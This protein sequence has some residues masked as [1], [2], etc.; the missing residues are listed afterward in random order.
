LLEVGPDGSCQDAPKAEFLRVD[1]VWKNKR[2]VEDEYLFEECIG[3]GSFGRV[4][5]ALHIHSGIHRAIKELPKMETLAEDFDWELRALIDLDHPHIVQ[6]IEH[7]EEV[8]KY[9]IVMELCTGPDLFTYIVEN[10]DAAD[11]NGP[12]FIPESRVSVILRQCLKAVLCCHAHGFIHRDLNAKNFMMTGSDQSVKLID[13][14]LATRFLPEEKYEEVVGTA[15]YMAPEMMLSGQWTTAVDIW[16]LGVVFFV[17]LTGMLLLPSDDTKK[18]KMISAPGFAQQ[19]LEKCKA[20][21]IRGLSDIARNLLQ[22]ML[23]FEPSA[24]I[25]APQALSH[26]FIHAHCDESLGKSLTFECDFD[27]EVVRKMRRFARAPRLMKV[28]LLVMAHLASPEDHEQDLLQAQHAFRTMDVN[29]DGEITLAEL[30]AALEANQVAVPPDLGELF[31]ICDSSS[32]GQLSLSEFLACV[33]P[34]N[35]LDEGLCSAVFNVL[36]RDYNGIISAEDLQLAH[37][38]YTTSVCEEMVAE[39]DL[40]QKGYLDFEDFR[41]FVRGADHSGKA[42]SVERDGTVGQSQEP[43]EPPQVK[44]RTS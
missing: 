8:D 10:T 38:S 3:E 21:Q 30:Q 1:M 42:G 12:R 44:R 25:T 43:Q 28:S 9:F 22:H 11:P 14:G 36:D 34:G 32:S 19:R 4:H 26:Q 41:L 29:G 20:L 5:K 6:V 39:A 40:H 13:F 31:R 33:L 24:R 15:H 37:P 35:L 27:R 7:F 18:K 17:A 23:M 16:S 2:N